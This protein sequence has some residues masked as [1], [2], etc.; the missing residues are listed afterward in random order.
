MQEITTIL[1]KVW[2]SE[3][4]AS[5]FGLCLEYWPV[6]IATLARL[7]KINRSSLYPKVKKMVDKGIILEH[8]GDLWA[9]FSAVTVSQLI[10][11]LKQQQLHTEHTIQL[12]EDHKEMFEIQ[13]AKP[14]TDSVTYYNASQVVTLLYDKMHTAPELYA[15]FDIEWPLNH[16]NMTVEEAV[17]YIKTSEWISQEILLDC[18]AAR[19][20]QKLLH[21]PQHQVK[22]LPTTVHTYTD[23]VLMYD[24][25][26]QIVYEKMTISA[27][28]IKH[29]AAYMT[30][31][32]IFDTLREKLP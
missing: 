25:F 21:S 20:Y 2:L 22:I 32:M 31:K 9:S 13:V 5:L 29:P 23:F 18:P 7:S 8:Q 1:Q 14:Q 24:S 27:T 6:S 30:Q 15:I 16:Y 28:E 26:F 17:D 4:E 12:L 3:E 19:R 10:T 11:L